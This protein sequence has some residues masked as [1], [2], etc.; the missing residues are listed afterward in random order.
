M[1][2]ANFLE[3][4]LD[5]AGVEW[6]ELGDVA[7]IK[8]GQLVNKHI[9]SAKPG[10][11]PVINSG[12]EPLGYISEWNTDNDPIGITTRGAGVGSVTWQE[13]KYYRGNLN[14]S[15]TVKA[16]TPINTRYLYHLLPVSYTHLTL[17]T[18][19]LV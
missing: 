10:A 19:L 8:T 2:S 14:Y 16:S 5:G 13:G 6:R 12:R 7:H 18:I 17:P 3:R 9:I 11:Y 15:V 4:L 1:S